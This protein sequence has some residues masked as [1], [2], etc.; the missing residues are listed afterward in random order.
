MSQDYDQPVAATESLEDKRGKDNDAFDALLTCQSG[1]TAPSTTEAYMLWAD[2]TAKWLKQRN[3]SDD[4]WNYL[5]PL[6]DVAGG[7]QVKYAQGWVTHDAQ[8]LT[9][10]QIPADHVMLR[11]S[12]EVAEAFDSDGTDFIRTGHDTDDDAY[13]QDVDVSST[14][15]KTLTDGVDIGEY[16]SSA[17]TPK[18]T[19]S[20]GGSEPTQGKALITFEF[21]LVDAE[22]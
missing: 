8:T 4:G 22:P 7:G 6:N 16:S 18:A 14:G 2:T 15:L 13:S 9:L 21:I 20:N 11:R 19:Y 17:R 10:D 3:S 12:T 5:W 1:T